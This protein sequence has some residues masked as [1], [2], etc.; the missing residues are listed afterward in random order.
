MWWRT[1]DRERTERA[2]GRSGQNLGILLIALGWLAVR[3]GAWSG[4]WLALIGFF[5]SQE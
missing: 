1:G 4:L 5:I 2:A 3:N